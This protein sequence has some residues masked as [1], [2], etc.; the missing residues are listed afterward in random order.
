VIGARGPRQSVVVALV[1][2]VVVALAAACGVP[3]QDE[4]RVAD[5]D[6]VPFGL[7]DST[8]TTA[9]LAPTTNGNVEIYLVTADTKHVTPV[10][11]DIGEGDRVSAAVESLVAGPTVDEQAQGLQT[12]LPSQDLVRSI[13]VVDGVAAVD[14]DPAFQDI[15]GSNQLLAIAQL[16]YTLTGLGTVDRVVFAVG[17]QAVE[18]P[19]GDGS[20]TSGAVSRADYPELAPPA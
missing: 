10:P 12:A 11:R 18:V 4:A 1:L 19:R 17:G 2:S 5:R 6:D 15:G 9:S 14:L 16:T 7:L 3:A 8:D 20:I 13:E